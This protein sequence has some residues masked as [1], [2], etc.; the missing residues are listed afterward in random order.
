MYHAMAVRAERREVLDR[1]LDEV[2]G[3]L[4]SVLEQGFPVMHFDEALT[5]F[6]ILLGEIEAAGLTRDRTIS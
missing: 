6:A 4:P 5:Y 3:F 2:G 1:F